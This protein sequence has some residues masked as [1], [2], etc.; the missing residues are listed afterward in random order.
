MIFPIKHAN[1]LLHTINTIRQPEN[2]LGSFKYG[3]IEHEIANP[4]M[5]LTS[6]KSRYYYID[7]K[8]YTIYVEV[9]RNHTLWASFFNQEKLESDVINIQHGYRIIAEYSGFLDTFVNDATF[10]YF[11]TSDLP[12]LL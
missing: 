2:L 9:D 7:S 8:L 10:L 4:P 1:L 12:V 3:T 5:H 6:G 11:Q